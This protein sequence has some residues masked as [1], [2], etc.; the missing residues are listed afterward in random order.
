MRYNA[1]CTDIKCPFFRSETETTISCEGAEIG[2]RNVMHFKGK[3]EKID[4]IKRFCLKY[5][6][7]CHIRN[8][9]EEKY[10]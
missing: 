2:I 10:K 5:P 4:Y 9:A 3:E 7:N 1:V 8:A 6:N